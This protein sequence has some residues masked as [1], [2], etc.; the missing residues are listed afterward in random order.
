MFFLPDSLYM[1]LADGDRFQALA[2][3]FAQRP[4]AEPLKYKS[5]LVVDFS[6][7]AAEGGNMGRY[8]RI[9]KD[10]TCIQQDPM[11]TDG[12]LDFTDTQT[13]ALKQI[14]EMALG[15]GDTE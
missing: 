5:G 4:L 9:L 11:T 6:V 1:R 3:N 2:E 8:L 15:P 12:A 13:N 14:T 7:M 10:L